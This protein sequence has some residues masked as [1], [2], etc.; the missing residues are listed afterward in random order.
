MAQAI[1]GEGGTKQEHVVLLI[2]HD[3]PVIAA[4][5]GALESGQFLRAFGPLLP[6]SRI[7]YIF[8]D[9]RAGYILT[10]DKNFPLAQSLAGSALQLIN[11]DAC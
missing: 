11:I 1:I 5:L 8:G 6:H 4:I 3:T 9:L 2:E 7:E 10:N